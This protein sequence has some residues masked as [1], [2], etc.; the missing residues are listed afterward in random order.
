M[1]ELAI[2]AFMTPE[3]DPLPHLVAAIDGAKEQILVTAYGFTHPRIVEALIGA[4]VR[5]LD[6]RLILDSSQAAGEAERKQIL[7]LHHAEIEWRVGRSAK[8][9]IIHLKQAIIDKSHLWVGSWNW[10]ESASKQDNDCYLLTLPV[11]AARRI[12]KFEREWERLK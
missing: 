1:Q 12:E 5:D 6:V 4:K 11:A 9:G 2:K 10:S 3:D 7:R 8:G